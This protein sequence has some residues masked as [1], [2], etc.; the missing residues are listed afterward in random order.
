M[1]FEKQFPLFSHVWGKQSMRKKMR[2]DDKTLPIAHNDR[3]MWSIL[4]SYVTTATS[5]RG[6][7]VQTVSFRTQFI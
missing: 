2:A 7:T 5:S 6:A 1:E 4:R 3:F